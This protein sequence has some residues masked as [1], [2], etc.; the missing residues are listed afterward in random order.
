MSAENYC[1]NCGE[2]ISRDQDTCANCAEPQVEKS[3]RFAALLNFSL[4][5]A[6]YIYLRETKKGILWGLTL[7]ALGYSVV[8]FVLAVPLWLF[9]IYSAYKKA[10]QDFR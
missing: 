6:G 2:T 3:P 4:P 8:G 5:G 1:W 9:G 7:A 10:K